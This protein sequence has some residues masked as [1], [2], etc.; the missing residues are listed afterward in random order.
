MNS[1]F[2]TED[3]LLYLYNEMEPAKAG[4]LKEELTLNPLLLAEYRR[5]K[6]TM[7][8]L[9]EETHEPHPT[10]INMV[11]DYSASFYSSE[12]HAE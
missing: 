4:A 8:K 12:H 1:N 9:D 5:L 3:L 11:M 10:T 6:E 2:T 7:A